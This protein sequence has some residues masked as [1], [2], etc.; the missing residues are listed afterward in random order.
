MPSFV[1]FARDS[2]YK[3]NMLQ[4]VF[5]SR[6]FF[7]AAA[8]AGAASCVVPL[9]FFKKA[10]SKDVY[11]GGFPELPAVKGK[12]SAGAFAPVLLSVIFGAAAVLSVLWALDFSKTGVNGFLS[13]AVFAVFPVCAGF[14][15]VKKGVFRE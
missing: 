6:I 12:I 3:K 13:A 4:N 11:A 10:R 5:D 7:C 15:A 2:R 9:L 1:A 8:L 14:Y